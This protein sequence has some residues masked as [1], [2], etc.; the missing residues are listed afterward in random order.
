[1]IKQLAKLAGALALAGGAALASTAPSWA[2]PVRI[3]SSSNPGPVAAYVA[4]DQGYYGSLPVKLQ[5]FSVDSV[6]PAALLSQSLD[7]AS[8]SPTTFIRAVDGGLDLVAISGAADTN[9]TSTE[10]G[11]AAQPD[12][13]IKGP[14]D[15]VGKT[16]GVPGIGSILDV[17]TRAWMMRNSVDPDKVHFVEAFFP[18]HR[19]LM[20][21]KRLD[22][23]VSVDPFLGRIIAEGIAKPVVFFPTVFGKEKPAVNV[24]VTTRAWA[25]ANPDKVAAIQKALAK[26]A[27]YGNAHQDELRRVLGS[28]LKLPPPVMAKLQLPLLDADINA[29]K[30]DWWIDIMRKQ[31]MLT[32]KVT[33]AN[34]VLH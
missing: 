5:L 11:I 24:F 7:V 27:D 15:L 25:K 28:M 21:A 10:S 33:G 34:L 29:Q 6:L 16:V 19:D 4:A 22:A 18:V 14:K 8:M 13:G 32:S 30:L 9:P 3:G 31:R 12:E 23:V 20:K 26:A 1:M 2:A 17:L